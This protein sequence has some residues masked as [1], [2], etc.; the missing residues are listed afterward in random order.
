MALK[1]QM[2]LK[3]QTSHNYGK[4]TFQEKRINRLDLDHFKS[5]DPNVTS[6]IPGINHLHTI[7]SKPL[8][9]GALNQLYYGAMPV[10][11]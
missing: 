6:V 1:Q 7:G 10:D 5:R 3:D 9:Y 4:M 8:A 11:H 2:A